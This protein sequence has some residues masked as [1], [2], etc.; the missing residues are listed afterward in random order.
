MVR[1]VPPVDVGRLGQVGAKARPSWKE[2]LAFSH[3]R[4]SALR[5]WNI[6]ILLFY[7][8]RLAH[9]LF[10]TRVVAHTMIWNS[11]NTYIDA[12]HKH[13]ERKTT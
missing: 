13:I 4:A 5:E 7:T 1:G 2:R 6:S 12:K 10:V 8:A 9:L 3:T 11:M